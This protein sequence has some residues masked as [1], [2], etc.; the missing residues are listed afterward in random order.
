MAKPVRKWDALDI[1]AAL[2]SLLEAF[3]QEFY[4]VPWAAIKDPD[5]R[6][7]TGA[8]ASNMIALG[9]ACAPVPY[10]LT[11]KGKLF[12]HVHKQREAARG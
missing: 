11:E 1:E 10:R 6:R 3:A 5:A 4:G 12:A 9:K 2:E 7:V 8:F